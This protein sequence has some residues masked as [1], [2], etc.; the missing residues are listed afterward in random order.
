MRFGGGEACAAFVRRTGGA[1]QE[2]VALLSVERGALWG[3][4]TAGVGMGAG[5]KALACRDGQAL[6]RR[7]A[8]LIPC[9]CLPWALPDCQ[10]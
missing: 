5:G 9:G 2:C 8:A 3:R 6:A 7:P 1:R 10:T 4:V